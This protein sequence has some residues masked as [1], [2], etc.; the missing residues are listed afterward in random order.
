MLIGYV[1]ERIQN[2]MWETCFPPG[3]LDV[4]DERKARSLPSGSIEDSP[5]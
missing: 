3:Q 5:L 1:S 2:L 4:V